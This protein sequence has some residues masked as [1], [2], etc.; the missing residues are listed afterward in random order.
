[1]TESSDIIQLDYLVSN[2]DIE[3]KFKGQSIKILTYPQLRNYNSIHEILPESKSACFILIKTS[4]H[5]GHWTVICRND[6]NLYYFDSY[7]VRPDEE[8]KHIHKDLRYELGEGHHYL[9]TLLDT[10]DFKVSYNQYQYQSYHED[11]NT[12]GKWCVVFAKA[13]FDEQTLKS[14]ESGILYLKKIYVEAYPEAD[15]KYTL[16]EIASRLFDSY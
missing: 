4:F 13:V 8:L 3:D 12:C 10:N 6:N 15:S 11:I 14:F 2:Y 5:S 16:D 1:M 9:T 7:G